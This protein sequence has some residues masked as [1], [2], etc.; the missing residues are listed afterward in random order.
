MQMLMPNNIRHKNIQHLKNYID[1]LMVKHLNIALVIWKSRSFPK[2]NFL[3]RNT[4]TKIGFIKI[5]KK[6]KEKRE[7]R[8]R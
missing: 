6:I 1:M 5:Y 2:L 3:Q 4:N 7:S 8:N